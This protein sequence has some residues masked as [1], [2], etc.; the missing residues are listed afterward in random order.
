MAVIQGTVSDDGTPMITLT[1]AGQDW[2]AIIDT[3]FNGDL[4][5]PERLRQTLQARYAG[6]V[7]STLAGG[8]VIEEDIYLV[9]FPFDGRTLLVEVTFVASSQILVG[10]HLLRDY[11]LLID[12]V[13]RSVLLERAS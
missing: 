2:P 9:T 1:I 12:F 4:E 10:T 13:N 7:T 8:R 5:L 3:G 11:R 6:R